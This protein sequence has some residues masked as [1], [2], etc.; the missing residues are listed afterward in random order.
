[1]V[2]G[3][4]VSVRSSLFRFN[5]EDEFLHCQQEKFFGTFS[6]DTGRIFVQQV[7]KGLLEG[8][9]VVIELWAKG[10]HLFDS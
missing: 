8:R 7:T 3:P 6:I 1:M 10:S 9:N 5:E 4:F 2:R